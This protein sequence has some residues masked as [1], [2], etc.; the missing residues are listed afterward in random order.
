MTSAF[1][2]LRRRPGLALGAAFS[3]ALGMALATVVFSMID[4]LYL[5]PLPF[6]APDRMVV[7]GYLAPGASERPAGMMPT[8]MAREVVAA[9]A[10]AKSFQSLAAATDETHIIGPTG[11]AHSVSGVAVSSAFFDVLRIRPAIGRLFQRADGATPAGGAVVISHAFWESQFGSDPNAIGRTITMDGVPRTVIGVV[12]SGLDYPRG[13]PFWTL[14]PDDT[15]RANAARS[16]GYYATIARLAPGVTRDRAA[17]E[18]TAIFEASERDAGV[19]APSRAWLA[20]L[21]TLERDAYRES[22]ELWV[23]AALVIVI[24]CAVNFATMILARGMS[25]R[26]ELAV[27]SALGAP[28]ERILG[29]LLSEAAVIAA[30][31]GACAALLA[32]WIL[33]L[34]NVAFSSSVLDVAPAIDWRAAGFALLGTTIVGTAFAFIPGVELSRADLRSMLSGGSAGTTSSAR[35]LRGRRGLVALQI[36][37]ALACVIVVAAVVR[38]D[39]RDYSSGPGYDY[40][41]VVTGSMVV[42]DS[43]PWSAAG[44]I[45][46]VRS[47]AGVT[48]AA[49]V[50][51]HE[52]AGFNPEGNAPREL[53]PHLYWSDVT[54]NYFSTIGARL[55][56]GRLPTPEEG[57]SGAPVLVVSARDVPVL[58]CR[59]CSSSV[60]PD[61]ITVL[62]QRFRM[63]LPDGRRQAYTVIGVV[64][65]IRT[66]PQFLTWSAPVYTVNA[67]AGLRRDAQLVARVHGDRRMAVDQVRRP[68][69][70]YDGRV[71]VSDLRAAHDDVAFWRG[72]MRGR[73]SFLACVAALALVLAGIGVFALAAHTTA[74][75]LREIG[76]RKALGA[77]DQRIIGV[78]VGDLGWMAALGCVFGLLVAGRVVATLDAFMQTPFA[79]MPIIRFP[80][81]PALIGTG[82]LLLIAAGGVLVPARR[83]LRMD[84]ARVVTGE[85]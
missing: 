12:P 73:L 72:Q 47:A 75:R 25:R 77:S 84:V 46:A 18:L 39:L 36:G 1:A 19:K 56:T 5:R 43:A 32:M 74:L 57:Q 2:H 45:A 49:V 42:T 80:V 78:I 29:L 59:L 70:H 53:F 35:E 40:E 17:A 66:A 52:I 38:G 67:I 31:G 16:R 30:C 60:R 58:W 79:P 10:R 8:V 14:I 3:L 61:S 82:T 20:P 21:A 65:D 22:L 7:V 41:N 28:F 69:Q 71:I 6:V 34:V 15:L 68:L 50:R 63:Q 83:A 62:G 85:R 23:A 51:N 37:L 64:D 27:R 26:S 24:L 76:I 54:P 33:R 11:Q 55:V 44:L 4:A 81:G 9:V 48:D 13:S